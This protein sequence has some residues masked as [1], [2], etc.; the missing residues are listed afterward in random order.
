MASVAAA[1]NR[2]STLAKRAKPSST[3][4]P[5]KAKR[6]P[7]EPAATQSPTTARTPAVT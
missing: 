6:V 4:D 7:A 1:P 2:M 5:W 3:N